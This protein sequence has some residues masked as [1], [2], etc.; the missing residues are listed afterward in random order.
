MDGRAYTYFNGE[1]EGFTRTF[2]TDGHAGTRRLLSLSEYFKRAARSLTTSRTT[3]S[4]GRSED[5]AI[6]LAKVEGLQDCWN[7]DRSEDW[8]R[9]DRELSRFTE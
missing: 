4:Q 9:M 5:K 7:G 6:Y 8:E 2:P 3:F 1:G